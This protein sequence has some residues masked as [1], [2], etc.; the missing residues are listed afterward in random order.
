MNQIRLLA[1]VC[2][3][4][5]MALVLGSCVQTEIIP[6]TLA[7]ELRL[8]DEEIALLVGE[9]TTL[10]AEYQSEAGIIEE[11]FAWSVEPSSIASIDDQGLLEALSAG[12][13]WVF[14]EYLGLRDS[15]LLS[16]VASVDEVVSVQIEGSSND[17][18]LGSTL[19]LNAAAFNLMG[20]EISGAMITWT[21]SD[22]AIASVDA[23]GIVTPNAV[24]GVEI[25]AESEQCECPNRKLCRP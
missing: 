14:V 19:N 21:S 1:G 11:G 4:C 7:P 15:A 23:N 18:V 25:F 6:E 10:S 22:E 13:A 9:S 2:I 12:Q 20:D 17:I 24:G 3:M 8:L 5:M 16:V